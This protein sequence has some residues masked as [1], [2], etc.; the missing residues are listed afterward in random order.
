MPTRTERTPTMRTRQR[1]EQHGQHPVLD[2]GWY[3]ETRGSLS[4]SDEFFIVMG[5]IGQCFALFS[6]ML[7]ESL[8]ALCH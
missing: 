4:F 5:M 2:S 3:E 7:N 6:A 8:S 1:G